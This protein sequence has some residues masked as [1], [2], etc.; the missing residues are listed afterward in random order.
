MQKEFRLTNNAS[1]NYIYKNGESVVT[2]L[3]NLLY[4]KAANIKVGVSVSKKIGKSVVRN[5][6]KRRIKENFRTFIPSITVKCNY[7]VAARPGIENVS[8]QYL[9]QELQK[10]L[11]KAGHLKNDV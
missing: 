1:Y 6:M 4:V 10:A 2:P 9:G 7:V 5:L 11:K 8:Y 3:F